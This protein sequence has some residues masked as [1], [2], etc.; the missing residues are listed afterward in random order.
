MTMRTIT[1]NPNA[2]KI[3][4]GL[5]DTG[6]EFKTAVADIVDNSIVAD[7]ERIEVSLHKDLAGKIDFYIL[8]DGF[9][10]DED[11]LITAMQYGSE[12]NENR[13]NHPLSLGKFGLGLKTASTSFCR[14]LTVV[15]VG[16]SGK[17]AK[18]VWDLD[19]INQTNAWDLQV[20]EPD[21]D[22]MRILNE[23]TKGKTGTLVRWGKVDRLLKKYKVATGRYAD[24]E[25][26]KYLEDLRGHLAMV[27]QRFIDPDNPRTERKVVLTLNRKV[28]EFW[29]PFR[30]GNA[31]GRDDPEVKG[32]VAGVE[33]MIGRFSV[34]SFYFP[35]SDEM[36]EAQ[37]DYSDISLKKQGIYV[38][39]ENRLIYGPAWMDGESRHNSLNRVRVEFSFSH[40]LDDLFQIDIKKS[41]VALNED[42]AGYLF[43]DFLSGLLSQA[44]KDSQV[45][46][47]KKFAKDTKGLHDGSNDGL[48]KKEDLLQISK[49]FVD[50]ATGASVLR[51]PQGVVPVRITITS[52]NRPGENY[53]QPVENIPG[54]NLWEPV[55]IEGHN[56]V[57]LNTSHEYYRK[58]YSRIKEFPDVVKAV[59]YLLWS[60]AQGEFNA[61]N[62]KAKD[63]IEEYRQQVSNII[64]TLAKDLVEDDDEA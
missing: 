35:R 21:A 60:L 29:D 32:T 63:F 34:R 39:R 62:E 27:F 12:N 59:D 26:N 43:K 52:A 11:E 2:S 36:D 8:D 30:H 31:A 33:K 25:F 15:S 45:G 50:P 57:R 41:Q 56:A 16:A 1:N 5:R 28:V 24:N 54:G 47:S 10:M 38:Y 17:P 23:F 22:E 51:N 3:I 14:R 7:A 4:E 44:K 6:Y 37:R 20:G 19:L 9:G 13:A 18:A 58:V 40:E 42:L 46:K 55:S 61:L 64:R 53:V 48:K 49:V